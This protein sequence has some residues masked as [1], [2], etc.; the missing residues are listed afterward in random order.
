MEGRLSVSGNNFKR[1]A[2]ITASLELG[3]SGLAV[4]VAVMI[5][6]DGLRAYLPANATIIRQDSIVYFYHS[7]CA[8]C[9]KVKPLLGMFE[10]S[11]PDKQL[12]AVNMKWSQSLGTRQVYDKFFKVPESKQ[13]EIPAIFYGKQFYIGVKAIQELVDGRSPRKNVIG[14]LSEFLTSSGALILRLLL[15]LMLLLAAA[16]M[17]FVQTPLRERFPNLVRYFLAVVLLL[18]S[19]HK[20]FNFADAAQQLHKQWEISV[21]LSSVLI[22]AGAATEL[23]VVGSLVLGKPYKLMAPAALVLFS[24]F[25]VYTLT[26]HFLAISGDCGC[27]PWEE[28]LGW[29]T[30]A[31]NIGFVVLCS[32]L[33][34]LSSKRPL[35]SATVSA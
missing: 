18:S 28:Q 16:Q 30:T 22:T 3:L 12:L 17:C 15:V 8:K 2:R 9:A 29:S 21:V 27:F 7:D 5:L 24:G 23:L 6:V 34:M 31:R 11:H 25:L 26:A 14:A 19:S 33:S 13:L 32:I 1:P 4:L 35:L 20:F 10:R